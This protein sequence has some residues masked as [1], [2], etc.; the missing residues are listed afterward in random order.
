MKNQIEEG[1]YIRCTYE[2]ESELYGTVLW[3]SPH[4]SLIAINSDGILT[5]VNTTASRLE[6]IEIL[7]EEK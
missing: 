4:V 2:D 6:T 1:D 3:V 7:E 5:H